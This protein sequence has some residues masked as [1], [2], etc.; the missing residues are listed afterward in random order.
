MDK[1]I[2]FI[3]CGNMGEAILGGIISSGVLEGKNIWVSELSSDRLKELSD[4]YEVNTT[5]DGKEVVKNTDIFIIAVKPNIYPVVLENI[6]ELIDSTKT[7]VTIAAGVTIASVENIIGSD[8]KII[9]T[10]PNTPALVGEGMTSISPN[11]VV[12]EDEV[13]EVKGIF[14]SFGKAEILSEYLIDSVIGVSGSAPAYVFMFIEA[15]ADGAVLEGMPRDKAYQ[16]AAQT[17]LGSAK[18]V[19][20]TGKHPGALKDAVCSPGGTTIEAVKVL[21]EEGFRK[22]VIKAVEACASKSKKMSK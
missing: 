4:K 9:R 13:E 19:L 8:K 12:K 6:K 22:A 7:V 11:G 3:G 17:V 20:E 5:T 1:K 16:F 2:G 21:E 18:M 15:L 14:K 10:M